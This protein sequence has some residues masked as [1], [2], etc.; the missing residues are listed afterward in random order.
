MTFIT[1]MLRG[2][3]KLLEIAGSHK[4]KAFLYWA[5]L[6]NLHRFAISLWLSIIMATDIILI[7]AITLTLGAICY[8]A[9]FLRAESNG[10]SKVVNKKALAKTVINHV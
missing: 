7:A 9:A 5:Y 1:K 6:F 3:D 2:T 8:T 10:G 4:L